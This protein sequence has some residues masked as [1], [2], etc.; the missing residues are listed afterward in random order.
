MISHC[1]TIFY[2]G[3][4]GCGKHEQWLQI[5]SEI[6]TLTDSWHTLAIKCLALIASRYTQG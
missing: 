3:L 5:R 1:L 2:A 4:L 6:E